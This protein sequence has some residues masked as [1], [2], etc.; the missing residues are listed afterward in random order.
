M[1]LRLASTIIILSSLLTQNLIA[2]DK[3]QEFL[4]F[5]VDGAKK[6]TKN[7]QYCQLLLEANSLR[8]TFI[9]LYGEELWKE[10]SWY[11]EGKSFGMQVD[12]FNISINS[13]ISMGK[14]LNS[15]K[16]AL[17]E[18]IHS[19]EINETYSSVLNNGKWT[20]DIEPN[21]FD[22]IPET[23]IIG[24]VAATVE[25]QQRLKNKINPNEVMETFHKKV[26]VP[27]INS[28]F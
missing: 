8:L 4:D 5:Y 25:A 15:N 10:L 21:G 14:V 24:Y 18:E 27:F 13:A 28:A 17:D 9:E 22:S 20:L 11:K 16:N 2:S 6:D 1:K 7:I 12:N 3:C 26:T 19:V 23:D